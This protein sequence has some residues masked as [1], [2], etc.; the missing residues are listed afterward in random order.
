MSWPRKRIAPDVASDQAHERPDQGRLTAAR[1]AD[2]PERLAFCQVERDVI[3]GVHVPT[4]RSITTP[5]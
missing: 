1:L 3:D 5:A 4:W 2:D